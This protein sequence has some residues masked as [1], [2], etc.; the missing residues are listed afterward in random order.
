MEKKHNSLVRRSVEWLGHIH[1]VAW[2]L[3][4]TQ[5][6]T[7]VALIG[8]IGAG[9]W[10]FVTQWGYLPIALTA[11][12]VFGGVLWAINGV[13]W[14]RRQRR[15]SKASVTF[16]YSY[17]VVLEAVETSYD[18]NNEGNSFEI[19]LRIRNHASGPMSFEFERIHVTIGD[20]FHTAPSGI[21]GVL[22]RV[23]A[24]TI[25]PGGGFSKEAVARFKERDHGTLEYSILYGHPEDK[26]SRRSQK[27]L[28]LDVLK[29]EDKNGDLAVS[30]N[31]VIRAQSDREIE[32]AHF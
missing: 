5:A 13:V 15:P 21:I 24:I 2:L 30:V 7:I 4:I 22:S 12:A 31:W 11:L 3:E 10:A 16:D 18:A 20:R 9:Y 28:H 32:R 23:E 14:L 25:F 19:R 29:M 26:L 8:A 27:T 1:L 6:T 17:G